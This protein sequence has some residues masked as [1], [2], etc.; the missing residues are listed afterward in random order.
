MAKV[1]LSDDPVS[2]SSE[3][4]VA[5]PA[6]VVK[7]QDGLIGPGVLDFTAWAGTMFFPLLM[8]CGSGTI[9]VENEAV[10]ADHLNDLRDLLARRGAVGFRTRI[11]SDMQPSAKIAVLGGYRDHIDADGK[12]VTSSS[13]TWTLIRTAA[14]WKVNLI[15]FNDSRQDASVVSELCRDTGEIQ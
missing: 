10:L 15:Q 4:A 8:V 12:T 7:S 2:F 14:G 13:M 9:V 6:S 3:A 1:V 11:N 5:S